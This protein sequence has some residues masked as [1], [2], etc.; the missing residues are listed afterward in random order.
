MLHS[1]LKISL[2]GKCL[3]TDFIFHL[4]F[5]MLVTAISQK[6]CI[7]IWKSTELWIFLKKFLKLVFYVYLFFSVKNALIEKLLFYVLIFNFSLL[8]LENHRHFFQHA[9]LWLLPDS[10]KSNFKS[11]R[12]ILCNDVKFGLILCSNIEFSAPFL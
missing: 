2:C 4:V 9:T 11:I 1:K 3:S 7:S 10:S 5:Y 6:A 8:F 12:N